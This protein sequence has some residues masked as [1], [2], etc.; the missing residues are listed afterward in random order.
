MYV[1]QAAKKPKNAIGVSGAI[2]SLIPFAV[3][4]VSYMIWILLKPELV[5]SNILLTGLSI[6]L[7]T[8]YLQV[9]D[10]MF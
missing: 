7:T 8:A 5:F 6:G 2:A 4:F 9:Q 10:K 3:V 1:F